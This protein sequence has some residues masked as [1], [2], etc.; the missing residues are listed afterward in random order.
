VLEEPRRNVWERQTLGKKGP[1]AP[2]NCCQLKKKGKLLTVESAKK[3][4]RWT[5]ASRWGKGHPKSRGC[6]VHWN[7]KKKEHC[8]Q[9]EGI[10]HHAQQGR[11][12]EE[13]FVYGHSLKNAAPGTESDK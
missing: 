5:K 10:G 4:N 9:L 13:T 8:A 12:G 1:G 11:T 6:W 3:K 2:G 7:L